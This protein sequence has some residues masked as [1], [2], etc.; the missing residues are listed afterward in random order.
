VGIGP[1]DRVNTN[2][3]ENECQR[4]AIPQKRGP[5]RSEVREKRRIERARRELRGVEGCLGHAT[6]H[7]KGHENS[8]KGLWLEERGKSNEKEKRTGRTKSE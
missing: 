2:Y 6:C 4:V 8:A 5:G 7:I 1:S 3:T